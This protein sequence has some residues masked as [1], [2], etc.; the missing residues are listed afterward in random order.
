MP[1]GTQHRCP[2]STIPPSDPCWESIRIFEA[3]S[4]LGVLP[5]PGELGDQPFAVVQ[6]IEIVARARAEHESAKTAK[7][8]ARLAALHEAQARALADAQ[9]PGRGRRR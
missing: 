9:A 2:W 1:E 6:A 8:N 5:Y 3:W 7:L 4:L